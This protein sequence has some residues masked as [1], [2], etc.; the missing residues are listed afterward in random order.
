ME[1]ELLLSYPKLKNRVVVQPQ[2]VPLNFT[3]IDRTSLIRNKKTEDNYINLFYPAAAYP[4]KNHDFLYVIDKILNKF[5]RKINISVTLT[6]EEFEPY[7]QL[8]QVKNL[9]RLNTTRMIQEYESV[10]G[11]LFLSTAESFGLPLLEATTFNLPIISVDLPY[12]RWMCEDSGVYFD[13]N[14]DSFEN[15]INNFISNLGTSI[16]YSEELKKFPNDWDEVTS[17]FQKL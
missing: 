1:T 14:E 3:K 12:A 11:L 16:N 13:L 6:N 5:E 8:N 4:H 15:A 17:F 2:P 10:D 7:M 9:G